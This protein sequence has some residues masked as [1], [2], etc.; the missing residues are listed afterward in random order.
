[1]ARVQLQRLS[2]GDLIVPKDALLHAQLA[3][4][5]DQVEGEGIVVVDDQ[6][7]GSAE[8]ETAKS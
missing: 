5:L 3:K 1:M 4:V 8:A 7:H 2:W 6:K